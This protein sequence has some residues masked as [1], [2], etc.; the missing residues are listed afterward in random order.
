MRF[1]AD[2]I[3]LFCCSLGGLLLLP[4][5]G[6]LYEGHDARLAG[7][8]DFFRKAAE[9]RGVDLS[10][11]EL[12]FSVVRDDMGTGEGGECHGS[13]GISIS[14]AFTDGFYA[15]FPGYLEYVVYHELGHCWLGLPHAPKG[16]MKTG[17]APFG[18]D[19]EKDL[20]ELFAN[21]D[22]SLCARRL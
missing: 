5:C 3:L 12:P 8:I 9:V 4:N 7:P 15:G 16:I 19:K 10:A 11:C 18:W 22:Q 1:S 17:S 14:N 2:R 20:D 21:I 13:G 6:R